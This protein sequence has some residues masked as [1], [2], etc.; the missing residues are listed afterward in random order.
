MTFCASINLGSLEI[1]IGLPRPAT[2]L[3]ITQCH[4]WKHF[5]ATKKPGYNEESVVSVTRTPHR[6]YPHRFHEF[7]TALVF[8]FQSQCSPI[9]PV[10]PQILSLYPF[11]THTWGW[12]F[13]CYF[14]CCLIISLHFN[15]FLCNFFLFYFHF[16]LEN[17][18]RVS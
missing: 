15:F 13:K 9:S 14:V 10:S 16:N 7:S 6:G 3:N 11:P 5:L 2:H 8:P 18:N 4:H 17:V 1:C 12:T